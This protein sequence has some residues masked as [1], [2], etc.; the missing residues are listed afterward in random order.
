MIKELE[1]TNHG[2][3]FQVN[4]HYYD[5]LIDI[6][7]ESVDNMELLRKTKPKYKLSY[8]VWSKLE[9]ITEKR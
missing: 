9:K 7:Q 3:V 6:F 1:Y 4:Q 5:I 2:M 8:L